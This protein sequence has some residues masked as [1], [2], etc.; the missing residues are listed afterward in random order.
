MTLPEMVFTCGGTWRRS[1]MSERMAYWIVRHTGLC[2]TL[3]SAAYCY[4]HWGILDCWKLQ[5]NS[6]TGGGCLARHIHPYRELL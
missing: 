2:V 1:G 4:G 5:V 3:S 6:H